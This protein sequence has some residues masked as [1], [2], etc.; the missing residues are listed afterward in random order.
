MSQDVEDHEL[1][2][3]PFTEAGPGEQ[4][5]QW[6]SRVTFIL[7]ASGSA[8]GLGNI[9]FFGANAYKYGGG[10]FY[11]PYFIALFLIGIP[12]MAVEFGLGH[13]Q[14]RAFPQ[15]LGRISGKAG[16]FLGWWA[17]ANAGIITMYYIALLAWVFGMM[18]YAFGPLWEASRAVPAFGM[19]A[20]ALPNPMATF[21][22][23]ISSWI[24]VLGVVVV[25]VL[26][27]YFVWAG[28]ESIEKAVRVFVPC[29]WGFMIILIVRGLT[30]DNGT[31]G[32]A[33][34][35]TPQWDILKEGEVWKGAMSQIFFTLS[36][37]FG[38]M[39]AYASYLPRD[40]DQ[41]GNAIATSAMNCFFEWMAG[42]AIFSILFAFSIAPKASTLSMTFFVLPQGIAQFPALVKTFG[43]LFFLLLLMAGLTSSISL[44]EGLVSALIDKFHLPRF[45]AIVGFCIAGMLGSIVFSLPRVVDAGLASNGTLGLTLLDLF[46]HWAFSYGLLVGGLGTVLIVAWGY[47]AEKFAAEINEN[48]A[49]RMGTGFCILLRYVIPAVLIWIIG[50]GI[51]GEVTG[52]LYGSNLTVTNLFGL[53][54]KSLAG[55]VFTVWAVGTL[56]AASA[57]TFAGKGEAPSHPKE[58][59][60]P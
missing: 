54:G 45:K 29:M 33:L 39:T 32:L 3:E 42:I 58:A 35:F 60:V 27:A 20:G 26:N 38:V 59:V 55:L 1:H 15:A 13:I 9:V 24:P 5:P 50:V 16:E 19:D 41:M 17:L 12:V 14:R 34:L 6:G 36:L 43:V 4:R 23:M 57:F 52:E 7:A 37:G 25:W 2:G 51:Y 46:D 11:L 56:L 48:S 49:F 30:L 8:I 31:H 18:F 28:T 22:H 21:F 10:A 44:V 47:G 40:S 53:D